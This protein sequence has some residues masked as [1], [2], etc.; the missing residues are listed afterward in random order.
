[1]SHAGRSTV[2]RGYGGRHQALRRRWARLVEAG[3]V[4]CARCGRDIVP[5]SVWNLGHVDGSGKL[6]YQGPEHERCNKRAGAIL[7][8]HARGRKPSAPVRASWW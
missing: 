7:G 2:E 4:C 8:N 1:M 3:G 6:E 5:G